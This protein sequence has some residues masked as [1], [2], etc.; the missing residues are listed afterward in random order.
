VLSLLQTE[1]VASALEAVL[2]REGRERLRVERFGVGTTEKRRSERMRL[3]YL[4]LSLAPTAA[5]LTLAWYVIRAF[6]V[7]VVWRERTVRRL[8]DEPA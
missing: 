1:P 6:S 5:V 3:A 4:V 7:R 8:D 2:D